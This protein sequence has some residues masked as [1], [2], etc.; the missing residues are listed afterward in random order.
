MKPNYKK[1]LFTGML[2]IA[3]T[4]WSCQEA[5][6]NPE[7]SFIPEQNP[8]AIDYSILSHWAAHPDKEDEADR[9]PESTSLR[10]QSNLPADVFFIHPTT[11]TG[12]EGRTS[13]NAN[14]LDPKLN[15]RTDESTIRFQASIFNKAGKV[16]APRYRQAHLHAYNSDDEAS[17]QRALGLAYKDVKAA[18]NYYLEH[19]HQDRPFI[20]AS[21]SQGTTHAKRLIKELVDTTALRENMVAAYLIGIAV[22]KDEFQNISPCTS[23]TDTGCSISWRTFRK[24]IEPTAYKTNERVLATNPLSWKTTHEYIPKSLNKGTILQDFDNIYP[25]L[26]DAQVDNG[27]LKVSKPSF[28]GSLFYTTKNYHIPDL[29]FFYFNIQENAVERVTEFIQTR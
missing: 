28:F 20:I 7:T 25:E 22:F 12:S 23:P 26:V 8:T 14:I 10:D 18:F 3:L 4:C 16:Y 13:W 2:V 24:D 19:H 29:N 5:W 9:I 1:Y 21:H 17:G 11:L 15:T 27:I 6:K